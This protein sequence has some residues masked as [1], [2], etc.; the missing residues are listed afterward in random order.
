MPIFNPQEP[1]PSAAALAIIPLERLKLALRIIS[2]ALDNEL[3]AYLQAAIG[4]VERRTSRTLARRR[5]TVDVEPPAAAN[6]A[7]LLPFYDTDATQSLMINFT[8]DDCGAVAGH[9][10]TADVQ[11][12]LVR[13]PLGAAWPQAWI[14]CCPDTWRVS[15]MAG[16]ATSA[17][18]PEQLL[19]AALLLVRELLD[20]MPLDNI[21]RNAPV[22]YLLNDGANQS[23][24]L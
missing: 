6:A 21:P 13:R 19:T 12:R 20:G 9:Y 3:I 2:D 1:V 22:W 17:E 8:T 24:H 14:D 5:R 15:V 10:P 4:F 18:C 11:G 23:L 16:Y 7:A